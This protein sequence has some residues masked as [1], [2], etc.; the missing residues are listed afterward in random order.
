[1]PWMIR[2]TVVAFAV[3]LLG[4]P[5]CADVIDASPAGFTI[6][7]ATEIVAV[8]AA[9]YLALTNQ[10]GSWWDSEHT[11]SGQA[12]NMSIDP[13]AGGCFCEKLAGGSV[14]HMRVLWIDRG[15][16]IRMSGGLGP[17]QELPAT[18]V[19]TWTLTE[20]SGRTRLEMVY[21]VGGYAKNGL[22]PLAKLVD[23]VLTH[24]LQR[25]KR[26]IETGRPQ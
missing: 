6:K 12:S 9:V 26:Y 14:E 21:A 22:E 20:V 1:M 15:K 11:Y 24:Q 10:I 7:T 19:L 25:A 18:G 17:L 8:P 13:R 4:S 16:V 23:S 2:I 3:L 5:L